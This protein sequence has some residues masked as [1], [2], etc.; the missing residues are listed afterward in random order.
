MNESNLRRHEK[1]SMNHSAGSVL[2]VELS[3]ERRSPLGSFKDK[4][5]CSQDE[6]HLEGSD[7]LDRKERG[8]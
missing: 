3:S 7:C 5:L 4:A 8:N 2:P 6:V 1:S